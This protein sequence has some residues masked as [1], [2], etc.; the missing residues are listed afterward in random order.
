[1]ICGTEVCMKYEAYYLIRPTESLLGR[2]SANPSGMAEILGEVR[3]WSCGEGG[4]TVWG[5]EDYEA[6]IKLL[7]VANLVSEYADDAEFRQL[8]GDLT[9]SVEAFDARWKLERYLL[10]DTCQSVESRLN[11]AVVDSIVKSGL[12]L[13]DQWVSYLRSHISA[14]D[15]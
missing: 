12:P 15:I 11:S 2:L 10:D 6:R 7:F 5:A 9:V 13:V 3:L 14:G 1:M 4:R 8:F